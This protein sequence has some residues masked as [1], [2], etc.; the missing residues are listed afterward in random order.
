[1]NSASVHHPVGEENA[2]YDIEMVEVD[3]PTSPVSEPQSEE[4]IDG[5]RGTE[6]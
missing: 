5:S 6:G 3:L 4:P 2:L 1:M